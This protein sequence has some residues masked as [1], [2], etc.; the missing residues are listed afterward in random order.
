[1]TK[2]VGLVSVILSLTLGSVG[3]RA[4]DLDAFKWLRSQPL[5]FFDLGVIR[6]E[7]DIGR[8]SRWLLD[9]ELLDSTPTSGVEVA[10]R[11]RT[12]TAYVS[13]AYPPKRRTGAECRRL[14]RRV[15]Q[16]MIGGAPDG[17]GRA[18]WY[19]QSTF[20]PQGQ[21]WTR[22]TP[23]FADRLVKLVRLQVVL[24]GTSEEGF[25]LRANKVSCVGTLDAGPADVHLQFTH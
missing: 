11:R 25:T 13:I 16:K 3:S 5:T 23:N 10:G 14:F 20:F 9:A 22:P 15:A 24:G 2:V 7:R 21:E 17:P 18:S 6:L 12:I 19:L 8:A 1:M 4:E